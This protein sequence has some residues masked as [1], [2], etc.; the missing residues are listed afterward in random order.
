MKELNKKI[1]KKFSDYNITPRWSGQVLIDNHI[2][3]KR[4]RKSH[5]PKTRY[6]KKI[7]YKKEVKLFFDKIKNY[8]VNNIISIDETSI[9]SAM[10]KE[11]CRTIKGKRCYFKTTDNK[12]FRKYTLLMAISTK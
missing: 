7:S 6:G 1:S 12:V 10:V 11:Y 3:R 8:N 4:T 5:F 2:T 9:K